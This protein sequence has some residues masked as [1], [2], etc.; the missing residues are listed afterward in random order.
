MYI[1]IVSRE[2]ILHRYGTMIHIF[3]K[4]YHIFGIHN[5]DPREGA[6]ACGID[7]PLK[8][9][10]EAPWWIRPY[11]KDE[12][13][14]T[15]LKNFIIDHIIMCLCLMWHIY[16]EE[17]AQCKVFSF[18]CTKPIKK[19]LCCFP[20]AL[21]FLEE[22]THFQSLWKRTFPIALKFGRNLSSSV[23]K[24]P[25]KLQSETII[26]TSNLAASSVHEIWRLKSFTAKWI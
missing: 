15:Y 13:L 25:V 26:I 2:F 17:N 3:L 20:I 16:L 22:N 19:C 11:E 12:E 4:G 14:T 18:Y 23:A 1:Y 10:N 24:M 8:R 5:R 7:I 21:K 6:T 9:T